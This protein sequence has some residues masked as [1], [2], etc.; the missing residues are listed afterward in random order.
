MPIYEFE[1]SKCKNIFEVL[2]RSSAENV[3]EPCPA[4]KSK[5]TRRLMSIFGGKIG[6]T[7][8]GGGCSSCAA[9]SCSP[10]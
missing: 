3:N 9:T 6:N 7:S 10:T 5:R 2:F 8:V 1:C 4:C